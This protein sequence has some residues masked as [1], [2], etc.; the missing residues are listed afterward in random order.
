MS[1][2]IFARWFGVISVL[3]SLG[4]LLNLEDARDMAK[5]MIEKE[6]GYIMGGVLPIIFGSL[7]FMHNH[8]FEIGWQLVV[9]LIGLGMVLLGT[10]RVFFVNH[11][12]NLMRQHIEQ[13]PPL[14]SLFGLLFGLLLLYVGFVSETVHYEIAMLSL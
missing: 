9:T 2:I 3:L 12:R 8:V 14:F 10:Y 11:W 1:Y 6:A 7:S 5:N 13:I 4:I